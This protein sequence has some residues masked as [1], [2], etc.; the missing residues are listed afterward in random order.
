MEL[1]DAISRYCGLRD[2]EE[3]NL[4][5]VWVKACDDSEPNFGSG[6]CIDINECS[7][8]AIERAFDILVALA[9]KTVK[10]KDIGKALDELI[11]QMIESAK[12]FADTSP[13][14]YVSAIERLMALRR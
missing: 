12:T 1:R 2:C 4:R 5:D 6:T 13:D 10:H 8:E 7:D 9:P 11:L 14:A 3:C